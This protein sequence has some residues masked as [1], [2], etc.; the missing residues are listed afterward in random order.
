MREAIGLCSNKSLIK[1]AFSKCYIINEYIIICALDYRVQ[2]L[3]R[4]CRAV[5][6]GAERMWRIK[7]TLLSL[8]ASVSSTASIIGAVSLSDAASKGR[9]FKVTPQQRGSEWDGGAGEGF[10]NLLITLHLL[11]NSIRAE[12]R[13][14]LKAVRG[15]FHWS[16]W[17][18]CCSLTLKGRYPILKL[19]SGC[20]LDQQNNSV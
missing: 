20:R 10:E 19:L 17:C 12:K 15:A 13:R 1:E 3:I 16:P 2:S 8:V 11:E 4:R 5:G 6:D 7:S 18:R 9:Y 14:S